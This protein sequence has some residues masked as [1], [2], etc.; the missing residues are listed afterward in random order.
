MH[1]VVGVCGV[2]IAL[3]FWQYT[4]QVET[5]VKYQVAAEMAEETLKYKDDTARLSQENADFKARADANLMTAQNTYTQEINAMRATYEKELRN[6]PFDT[7]NAFEHRLAVVMCKISSG[8]N[9]DRKACDIQATAPYSPDQSLIVTVTNDTTEYW[10]EQCE[11]GINDFCDY[12]LIGITTQGALTI[13]DYLNQVDRYIQQWK[14]LSE[15]DGKIIDVI[16]QEPEQ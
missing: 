11:E 3:L 4:V 14:T 15:Y 6:Q 1:Y 7:G 5:R 2:I 16:Q 9:E 8:N 13:L 10:R 12:A